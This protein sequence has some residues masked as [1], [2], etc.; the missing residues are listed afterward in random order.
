M[1][2]L[3]HRFAPDVVYQ[4]AATF[5]DDFG[6]ACAVNVESSRKLLEEVERLGLGTRVILIGS[7]AEYGVVNPE[8]NPVSETHVLRPVSTYGLTKAWQ[9]QLA[10]FYAARGVNVSIARIFN[11]DGPGL[12]ERLFAGRIS[13]QIDEMLQKRRTV[14]EVGSLSATRDYIDVQTAAK[15]IVAV[16]RFGEAGQVYHIAS[17]QPVTMREFL[18]KRLAEEGLD[19]GVVQ[20]S[21]SLSNRKGYD[22]PV[23]YA[24]VARILKLL[25]HGELHG[26]S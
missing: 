11:L 23:I 13:R 21:K 22:V 9:T 7:A 2:E 19:F 15:Q 10:G 17:G 20:E 25:K 5:G 3:L 14:I 24:D 18:E 4:L 6:D 8:E 16:A 12:S 26:K 1:S